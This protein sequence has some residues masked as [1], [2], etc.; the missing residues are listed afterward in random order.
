MKLSA[1]DIDWL[2]LLQNAG[3][4]LFLAKDGLE[5]A[6]KH[7]QDPKE[8]EKVAVKL[9]VIEEYINSLHNDLLPGF[10]NKST[11]EAYYD[12]GEKLYKRIVGAIR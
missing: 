11:A 4:L 7:K 1:K 5:K 3:V 9:E 10:Q 8:F 2:N 12:K 6:L